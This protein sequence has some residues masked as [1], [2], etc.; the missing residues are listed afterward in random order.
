MAEFALDPALIYLNHAAVAPWPQS[1]VAAVQAFARENGLQGSQN[2]PHW[3]VK[4]SSLRQ[5]MAQLINAPNAEDIALLKS[6]SEGLSFVAYGLT[7]QAGDNIVSIAQEFPSNRIVWQSLQNQG[8]EVRLLDLAGSEQPEKDLLALCDSRTKLLSVSSIQYASGR[9][10][11][12]EPLGDYCQAR[13]IV[14]VVDAIQSLGAM[15]FDVQSCQADVV[16][17]DGHK[18]MLGPEGLALFY[19]RPALR[20]QL[21]LN[22][23]GW[24][25]VEEVGDFDQTEWQ[26]AES[27]RRF[28]CGSPNMLG[29]H[30][31]HNSLSLLLN[32][33][34]DEVATAIQK[35]T[36]FTIDQVD[37]NHYQL[38]TPR[39]SDQR[40]GIVTFIV[41]DQDNQLLYQSLME[42]GVMCAYRGGGIRF[43]PHFYNT[44]E[45][46]TAAFKQLKVL[47]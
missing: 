4:E 42:Q 19:C 44:Q 23:Y 22:E 35:L 17:A 9:R 5:L 36:D 7:W 12:L 28:E 24:H 43:S 27:A 34:L 8:V 37:A 11:Q 1:T 15:P 3:L 30:A 39:A 32:Q 33:G 6:T 31:L 26:A 14:F 29:V 10:M 18:W 40:G 13:D 25:M 47:L 46:I 38:I 20:E 45:Q 41:P 2:Y 21:K 16:V